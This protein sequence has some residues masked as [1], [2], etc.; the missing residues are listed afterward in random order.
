MAPTNFGRRALATALLLAREE[1][2]GE[3]AALCLVLVVP[4]WGLT[5]SVLVH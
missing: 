2:R 5:R 3:T 4:C 1:A